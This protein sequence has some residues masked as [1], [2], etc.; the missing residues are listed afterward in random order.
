MGIIKQGILGGFSNKVGAVVGSSWKGIA[1]MK[2]KPIS[3]A[4]PR[5]TGQVNQRNKMKGLTQFLSPILADWIKPLVDRFAVKKSGF[6]VLTS[7]NIPFTS[8]SGVPNFNSLIL[9]QGKLAT[10]LINS[11]GASENSQSVI[12]GFSSVLNNQYDANT[13]QL[14]TA[15]YN[16]TRSEWVGVNSAGVRSAGSVLIQVNKFID[17][18]DVLF[19]YNAFRRTDGT[20]V[21]DNSVSST[22]VQP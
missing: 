1:V 4:N 16:F 18:S 7:L 8:D 5:T 20:Y 12:I 10:P 2:S 21:S 14:F 11:I 15:I 13:D 22:V 19:V 3:V 6:N 9:S 17:A